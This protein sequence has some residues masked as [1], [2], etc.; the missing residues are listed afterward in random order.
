M[1]K[2]LLLSLL[3][4]FNTLNCVGQRKKDI[5]RKWFDD[6]E[7]V[8]DETSVSEPIDFQLFC[9]GADLQAEIG[10]GFSFG[11]GIEMWIP[12]VQGLRLELGAFHPWAMDLVRFRSYDMDVINFQRR[13]PQTRHL[14]F[15]SAYTL[16]R[17]E[18]EVMVERSFRS[19]MISSGATRTVIYDMVKFP[20]VQ[21]TNIAYRAKL[22]YSSPFFVGAFQMKNGGLYRNL[23]TY[24]DTSKYVTYSDAD[25]WAVRYHSIKIAA[26]VHYLSY[27]KA[28]LKLSNGYMVHSRLFRGFYADIIVSARSWF[29]SVETELFNEKPVAYVFPYGIGTQAWAKNMGFGEQLGF[30]LGVFWNSRN[31]PFSTTNWRYLFEV[32]FGNQSTYEMAAGFRFSAAMT[33][34]FVRRRKYL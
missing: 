9:S 5:Q 17:K 31:A 27:R 29:N 15:G 19:T 32:N 34:P 24:A 12:V 18:K 25:W 4:L 7:I 28:K 16:Y 33:L 21:S 30:R 22:L 3:L 20:V 6:D 14:Q 2:L 8:S 1:E 10:E 26:G 13:L 11:S 23:E